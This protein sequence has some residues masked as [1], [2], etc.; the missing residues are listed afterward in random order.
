MGQTT[1]I[2][3]QRIGSISRKHLLAVR[4]Y[5]TWKK[6]LNLAMSAVEEKSLTERVRAMP[7]TATI[8]VTNACNLRCPGCPTGLGLSGRAKSMMSLEMLQAF[9]D[10][11]AE[12]LLVAHLYNWGEPLLHPRIADIVRLVHERRIFTSMSS[13]LSIDHPELLVQVCDAGWTT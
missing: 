9:L 3:A 2:R 6:L 4:E 7:Y 1:D 13:H 5:W 11:T 10:Q 8:D 12:Y